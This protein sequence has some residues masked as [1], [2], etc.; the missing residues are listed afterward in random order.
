MTNSRVIYLYS[1]LVC[2]GWSYLDIFNRQV[3][4]SFP[5]YRCLSFAL[6]SQIVSGLP[7]GRN[8]DLANNGLCMCNK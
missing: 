7:K 2:L 5:C 6:S 4:T 8:A 1:N 3:F